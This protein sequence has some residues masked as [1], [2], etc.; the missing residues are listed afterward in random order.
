MNLC[1][2]GACNE[3]GKSCFWLQAGEVRL[4]LDVGIRI[5]D[6]NLAP[7]LEQHQADA[8]V[9]THAHMDHSGALPALYKHHDIPAF[10]TFPTIP[11]MNLL[12]ADSE[13]VALQNRVPL[14]YS[15]QHVKR[16]NK[17]LTAL[18]YDSDYQFFDGT[19]LRFLDAGHILGSAQAL[20]RNKKTLLYTGDFKTTPTRMHDGAKPPQEDVDVLVTESTYAQRT[21]PP[22]EELEKQFADAVN[23]AIAENLTVLVPCFAV[24]RTQE[25]LQV[26][27]ARVRA[28]VYLDGMGKTVS[29]IACD[30][31]SYCRSSKALFSAMERTTLVDD[32]EMRR[33]ISKK[34]CVI[35]STAGML[36]GGPALSYM[37]ELNASGKGVVFL[38]GYQVAGTNGRMLEEQKKIRDH[39]RKMDISLAVRQFDFSAH[40]GAEDLLE[41]ARRVNPEKIFCI[42]GDTGV[43]DALAEQ[44]TEEEGFDAI[45]PEQDKKYEV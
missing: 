41:Y 16:M 5:H 33:R 18:S 23:D 44:L 31:P 45:A 36:D 13:K 14:P 43:C 34:P 6:G 11:V 9:I 24:G 30:F 25:I 17:R 10:M 38:T 39:G 32:R 7:N 26:L 2:L 15:S 42:H 37:R 28:P 4:F 35:V 1:F 22:R 21:H 3:V 40:A 19:T 29:Q 20:I 27:A 8:A 12:L